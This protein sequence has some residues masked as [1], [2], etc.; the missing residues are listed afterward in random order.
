MASS[1]AIMASV[2]P[3]VTVM[4]RSGST[5]TPVVRATFCAIASRRRGEPQVMAYWL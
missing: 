4:C 5:D 2:A 1:V 3:Q